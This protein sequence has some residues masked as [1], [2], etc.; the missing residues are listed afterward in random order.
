MEI[1]RLCDSVLRDPRPSRVADIRKLIEHAVY[2]TDRAA[3]GLVEEDLGMAR[4]AREQ[5]RSAN[6]LHSRINRD[7]ARLASERADPEPRVDLLSQ[8][9]CKAHGLIEEAGRLADDVIAHLQ[10]EET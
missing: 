3:T 5:R 9:A 10:V 6:E 2:I 1:A 7:L 4:I 8:I